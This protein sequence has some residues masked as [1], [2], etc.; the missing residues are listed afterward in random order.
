[1]GGGLSVVGTKVETHKSE[2]RNTTVPLGVAVELTT[3]ASLVVSSLVVSSLVADSSASMSKSSSS[4]RR[5]RS[6]WNGR[7]A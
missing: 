7:E 6:T 1:M 5:Q 2:F 4:S 3:F